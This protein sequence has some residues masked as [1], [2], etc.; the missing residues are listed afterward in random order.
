MEQVQ[1]LTVEQVSQAMRKYL[2]ADD[3][4]IVTAGPSVAQ[5]PLPPPT[6]H[7]AERPSAVPEH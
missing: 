3:F 2:S 7:P 5:Q 6:D 1:A 4:V